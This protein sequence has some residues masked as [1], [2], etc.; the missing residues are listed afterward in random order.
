MIPISQIKPEK[1]KKKKKPPLQVEYLNY[2]TLTIIYN[3]VAYWT[4]LVAAL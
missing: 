3:N 2:F 1:K 4:I